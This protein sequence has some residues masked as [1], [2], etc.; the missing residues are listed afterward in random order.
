MTVALHPDVYVDILLD[1]EPLLDEHEQDLQLIIQLERTH[2]SHVGV[3]Y[4]PVRNDGVVQ[5]L[6]GSGVVLYKSLDGAPEWDILLGYEVHPQL[7][8][9]PSTTLP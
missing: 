9:P 7:L 2:P 1:G 6:E 4:D 5:P 8:V 3:A